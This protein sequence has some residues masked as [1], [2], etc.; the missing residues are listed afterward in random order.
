MVREEPPREGRPYNSLQEKKQVSEKKY[1]NEKYRPQ[2]HFTAKENWLNDPN[3]CVFYNGE[4][5]LFFQH[6]PASCE[7][8]NMTWGHAI[9]KDL[10]NWRQMKHAL[11]PYEDGTI[12]SGSAVVD[13]HNDSKLNLEGKAPLIA[14]FTHARKPFGQAIAFSNDHGLNWQYYDK[15]RHVVPNQGLDDGERDPKIFR[16]EPSGKWIM[17][18]WVRKGQVR[19]F[20]SDNLLKWKHISDFVGEGFYECPDLI[21]LPLDGNQGNTKWVLYDAAFNYWVGSFDGNAFEA[22]SG[23]FQGD[24]GNNFY[25][26]QTW[27][28][29][30][31]RV[32]QI[33]WMRGG[34]YP[35]MPFNQ[36]M[37]FSC[38]LSLRST[39]S[40]IRLYRMPVKEIAKL[41]AGNV[42]VEDHTLERGTPLDVGFSS[43]IF[44]LE[45]EMIVS[46]NSSFSIGFC[47]Q[48]VVYSEA[49]IKC[50]G[51]KAGLPPVNDRVSLRIL[52]DRTSIE[53]FGNGG[54]IS[55]SSCFLPSAETGSIVL[56][57]KNGSPRIRTLTLHRLTSAWNEMQSGCR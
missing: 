24:H 51:Q 29:T 27:N 56:R 46:S 16:H 5:H 17:V 9:S 43:D 45:L 48:E 6:N 12:F 47:G 31:D 40:G 44:D 3:G 38:E 28:N 25:A 32:V 20:S 39:P 54:E 52:V 37:S 34:Q 2:F 23:P 8:G 53:L 18:L 19:F 21:Q 35:G 55:M 15:G 4:Y 49:R 41:R 33:G 42:F 7:W 1:Y 10:V 13:T 22:E 36:Q 57:A 50:L 11:L 14:A 26:A 30:R